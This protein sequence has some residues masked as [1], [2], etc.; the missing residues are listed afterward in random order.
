MRTGVLV[1]LPILDYGAGYQLQRRLCEERITERRDNTLVLVEHEAVVTLGRTTQAI[2]WQGNAEVLKRQGIKVLASERGGSVTYHGPGQIIG[3]PI[4]RLRE[5]CAGPKAYMHLLE[6]CLMRVL[7]DWG[8]EGTRR[9]PLVG[10]WVR[11]PALP[12]GPFAKIAALGVKIARGVTMHG[13]ALNVTVELTP[14]QYIVPC[15]LAGCRVTSMAAVLGKAPDVHRVRDRIAYH[16][17]HVFGL[18]WTE[19]CTQ[20]PRHAGSRQHA[21]VPSRAH[22]TP[23]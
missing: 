15:G 8:L 7:A 23:R 3:Y 11:D 2:H 20:L 10:V 13:F 14:F 22:A 17:A 6:D 9:E 19:T 21:T 5:F 1:S 16:F 4:I 12:G 18:E